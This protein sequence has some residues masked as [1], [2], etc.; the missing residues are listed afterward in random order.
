[1]SYRIA[2][3]DDQDFL[4]EMLYLALWDPPSQPPRPRTVLDHPMIRAFVENWGQPGDWALI[5]EADEKVG[6]IWTRLEA[7]DLSPDY[8]CSWPQL[9]MALLPSWQGRGLGSRLMEQFIEQLR[10]RTGGLRLGV[11]PENAA[12]IRLYEKFGFETY[13]VGN[14]DYPQMKLEF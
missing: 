4:R 6:A 9:G 3:P 10:S 14:G 1:M 5:A 13:A 2:N 7:R 11:H 12:A 8:G